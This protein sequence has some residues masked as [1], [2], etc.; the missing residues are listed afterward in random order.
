MPEPPPVTTALSPPKSRIRVPLGQ[1]ARVH[2]AGRDRNTALA[3]RL[4]AVLDSAH[5]IKGISL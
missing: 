4:Q 2:D 5:Q 1:H 3:R